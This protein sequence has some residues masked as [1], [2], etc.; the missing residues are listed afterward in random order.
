MQTVQLRF[1]RRQID[2][3]DPAFTRPREAINPPPAQSCW[4]SAPGWGHFLD[5]VVLLLVPAACQL[6]THHNGDVR[7]VVASALRRL[8]PSSV[9]LCASRAAVADSNITMDTAS[10]RIRDALKQVSHQLRDRS[11]IPQYALRLLSDTL[12]IS[13]SRIAASMIH[14]LQST[15]IVNALLFIYKTGGAGSGPEG[16]DDEDEDRGLSADPQLTVFLSMLQEHSEGAALLLERDIATAL[17][18]ALIASVYSAP[19]SSPSRDVDGP[20][21][22]LHADS[23]QPQL[24][25]LHGC[26]YFVLKNLSNSAAALKSHSGP[27]NP[28]SALSQRVAMAEQYRKLA[29]PLRAVTPAL[30]MILAKVD[31]RLLAAQDNESPSRRGASQLQ[32]QPRTNDA[33]EARVVSVGLAQSACECLA[34]LFDLF[35]EALCSQVLSRQPITIDSPSNGGQH[36]HQR[37]E[38]L[39]PRLVFAR[40]LDN[41]M[42][43]LLCCCATTFCSLCLTAPAGGQHC[44]DTDSAA[45]AVGFQGTLFNQLVYY[46]VIAHTLSRWRT[47]VV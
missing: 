21:D 23:V 16:E 1:V 24:E 32:Q 3:N 33:Q 22:G 39:S 31:R 29:G 20:T 11:P 2:I 26:L 17:S 44:E 30:L 13:D 47:A 7:V 43:C 35:Q 42:V 10:A 37:S 12:A 19:L 5:A 14:E 34:V 28:S 4:P 15:D 25:L 27:S 6:S 45:L 8:V 41:N 9:R 36:G 38:E 46:G 40:L 18:S